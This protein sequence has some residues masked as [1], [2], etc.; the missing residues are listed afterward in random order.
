MK[1]LITGGCGFVGTNIAIFLFNK[2]HKIS[3]LDNLSRKGSRYNLKLLKK[4]N[5][6]NYNLNVENYNKLKKLP[7][8]DLI[9]DCCAEAAVEVSRKKI[10]SVINTNLIGTIN[11]LKKV[12]KDNSK[13]IF[14]SSSRVYPVKTMN[15]IINKKII[16]KKIKINKM[17][18]ENDSITGPKT[19]YGLTKLSSEMFIEEFSYAYGIKYIINRCGVISG[20][21]QFG[22]Q[23]QGFLSLWIWKHLNKKNLSYIGYGGFGNQIRD[24]LHVNDLCKLI[25]IQ[26]KKF[27]KINN[28]IYT[29]GGSKKSFTSLKNLTRIC[30]KIT[31]NKIKFKKISKTSIYDIPYYISDNKKISKIYGWKPKKDINNIVKDTYDWLSQNKKTLVKYF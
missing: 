8:Y 1:I 16:K 25:E 7:K 30:E 31:N 17:I 2:K 24:V 3:T 26:I 20:P 9:I 5:I 18:N 13:I 12:K 27:T 11:I 19:I 10:D 6:K 4:R 14:L 22:K 15:K 21:L 23:D 29:V 28:Q